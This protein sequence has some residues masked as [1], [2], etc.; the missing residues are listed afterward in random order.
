MITRAFRDKDAGRLDRTKSA[1]T[2]EEVWNTVAKIAPE[3]GFKVDEPYEAD[4]VGADIRIRVERSISFAVDVTIYFRNDFDWS[5][6]FESEDGLEGVEFNYIAEINWSG[7]SRDLVQA[8]TSV[9]LYQK[10]LDFSN[11]LM[12]MFQ[13]VQILIKEQK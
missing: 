10:A 13:E 2:R 6:R 12:A 5:K 7:T 4:M 8:Q 11:H 3:Y 1:I 9:N